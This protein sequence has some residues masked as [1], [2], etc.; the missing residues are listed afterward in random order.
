MY[1][2]TNLQNSDLSHRICATKNYK[3]VTWTSL[4]RLQKDEEDDLINWTLKA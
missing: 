3:E 4:P 1:L 2:V